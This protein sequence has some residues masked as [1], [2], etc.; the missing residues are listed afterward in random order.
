MV[1]TLKRQLTDDE[2]AIVLKRVGQICYVNGHAIAKNEQIHFD[3]IRAHGL[4]G[5]TELNNI[6]PM[7]GHHNQEK[8]QLTLGDFRIKLQLDE[9]FTTGDKLTLRHLLVFFVKQKRIQNFGQSVVIIENQNSI[10]LESPS[11]KMTHTLYRCPTTNWNYFYATLPVSLLDSDDDDNENVGL[12]PRYL[13]KDK[14]FSLFRHFQGHPV[15]QPSIGR[16][17]GYHIRLFDGQH[18]IAALLLN[19]HDEVEC[20]IYVDPNLKLLNDTNISAHDAFAQTRFYSSIMILKLGAEFA[21]D[22]DEFKNLE[23]PE[24]KSEV[25]FF[26]Y[27]LNQQSTT[28]TKA[29]LNRRFRSYLYRSVLS[30]PKN[31]LF[32][33]VSTAN[34]STDE[35]PITMDMLEKSIFAHFIFR[36]PTVDSMISETYRRDDEFQNMIELCNILVDCGLR[37]W[38]PR[39][40]TD[41]QD[42]QRLQRLFGSKSMMAWSELL[43]DAVCAR[44]ELVDM[45]ER[46]RVFYRSLSQEQLG[47]IRK[48]VQRLFEWQRWIAPKDD[49]IDRVLSDK[50]SAVKDWFR[51]NGLTTGFLMGATS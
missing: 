20:K 19:N 51:E 48:T 26:N 43:W 45:D 28:L 4:G 12:Q 13:I 42:R 18:K 24:I 11:I 35:Q 50:K 5:D 32:P 37:F 10:T 7:C 33:L 30:D 29:E 8:G 9:F 38:N 47:R 49:Q 23:Q 31:K 21:K 14:V 46:K 34:R 22:F 36:E 39:A 41:D 15:L 6:A 40:P 27:L 1:S 3:H 2:K 17:T 44:L 25:T 16:F